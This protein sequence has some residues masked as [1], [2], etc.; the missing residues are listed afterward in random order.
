M[1]AFP[2]WLGQIGLA[3]CRAILHAH[4]IDFDNA[5][6]LS[7][8]ALCRLGLNPSDSRR[9]VRALAS[10]GQ[11]AAPSS[12]ETAA[13][14][15]AVVQSPFAF[16]GERRQQLTVMFCDLVGYTALS[17]RL[18]PE[19]LR[20]LRHAFVTTCCD[21]V[22]HYEGHVAQDPGDALLIYFG[23]PRAHENDAERCV[24]AALE[25]V[26][27]VKGI[28]E[29]E[30]LAV[31][32]G[33]ATGEVV[34]GG[35]PGAG[36]RES[37]LA[38]GK[39]T[40]VAAR[41]QGI[42]K[43]NEILI[44]DTTRRLL[45]NAFELTDLGT[46]SL[47]GFGKSQV[48]R[49]E[50]ERRAA[51]RFDSAHGEGPLST[52]VGRKEQVAALLLEWQLA[53]N[54]AG[55]VVLIR[56][57]AGIGK[58]RL[59]EVLRER[60]A[61]EQPVILRYQ[62]SPFHLNAALHP[63]IAHIE[64]AA[65]FVRED[66]TAQKLDKLE[67]ILVGDRTEAAPLLAALL[68]LPTDRYAPLG[69]SA[70]RQKEKTLDVLINQVEELARIKP[71]LMVVE[72]VHWTD[73][74]SQELVDALV[75]RLPAQ[76]IMLVLTY[77]SELQQPYT[78]AW[79]DSTHV[80]TISLDSL[81][82]DEVVELAATVAKGKTL[83]SEVLAQIVERA[84]GVPLFIEELTKKQLESGLLLEGASSYTLLE[85][86]PPPSIP[87]T[88]NSFLIERLDRHKRAKELAQTGAALG[89]VFSYEL[90]A[91]VSPR[92][93]TELDDELEQLTRTELVFR[94]GTPPDATYTFKHALVQD[95][96]YHSLLKKERKKLHAHI[97]D[98]LEEEFPQRVANEP[99]LLAYHRTEADTPNDLMA[100]IPL[101]Q[102][103]GESA[104]ARMAL[105]EAVAYLDKG[106]GIVERLPPSPERDGLELSLREPLHTARLRWRGWSSSEVGV[107][108]TAILWLA[109][110][111]RRSQGLLI[112][113][114]GMWINT[115]TQ[116]RVAETPA[117]A[118]RLLEEGNQ[119]GDLD[120]LIFGHRAR[121]S[122]HF[123][124]GELH[125]A[126]EQSDRVLALYDPRH[127]ARWMELTGNDARTAV[128]IFA[129]QARWMLGF[130]DQA[131]QLS[132]QKDDDAR[133]L[134][135]PFDIGWAVTWGAYVF[136]YRREPD[137]LL[138]RVSEAA[139]LGREQSIPV[140]TKALVPMVEGLARLRL[141]QLREARNLL[142]A[143]IDEW[144]SRG[145]RLNVPYLEAALAEALAL[146]GDLDG[147]LR[148]LDAC[149]EQIER[150]GWH[151]R[152]WLPETLRLKGWV[153]MRQG[154]TLEAETQLR[155]S[156]E[157]ARAQQALS[158]ELRSATTLA[159]LLVEGGKGAA[160]RDILKPV[161]DEFTEGFETHDL[162]TARSLLASLR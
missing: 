43:A 71:V 114:W 149:V 54:G 53:R 99:E 50:G 58:S 104:L 40:N 67:K 47:E 5:A 7:E 133:R 156:I 35:A 130:P 125:E 29:A 95:A 39:T 139:R 76:A 123:Y 80:T 159:E 147:A 12:G 61:D 59:T 96:A 77:R 13:T 137:Q 90:L 155:A 70:Q 25:I 124:L 23:W 72:D 131:A 51:A 92:K 152:V 143:G 93:G 65:G 34:V 42:A 141:G 153:L 85:P 21:R 57:E 103:A 86:L 78:P 109:Q 55:R 127:A 36:G 160:A 8:D 107:N 129:T 105:Q 111:Q 128:G 135:N 97:A 89:R 22:T 102:K 68:S 38:Y 154:R 113:L 63:V 66:S 17:Q 32:I 27:A 15:V 146:E 49:M 106:L 110:K 26:R 158:W 145:G 119:S 116:G 18:D 120:L 87:T 148:V 16:H 10:R 100:A 132:D 60:I 69:L 82:P 73:P 122:S 24:L 115:I 11:H 161:Y 30:P 2:E 101:W 134:G 52:L 121:V 56:G 33:I 64:L 31:H 4:G 144:K 62:C 83:P 108:A 75:P 14:H 136:D 44:E 28:S 48:W 98:V 46:L 1:A 74:T 6:R 19:E 9:L 88:L 117:W 37:G 20:D 91:A 138:T 94:R 150:P 142:G 112:G 140:L 79:I 118:R 3:H 41:L 126:L 162:R 151:E 84:D 157:T 81:R 45:R